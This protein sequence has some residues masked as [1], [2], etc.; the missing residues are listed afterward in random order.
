MIFKAVEYSLRDLQS[1][2]NDYKERADHWA[3]EFDDIW[4]ELEP[5]YDSND[6]GLTEPGEQAQLKS[7]LVFR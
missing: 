3:A 7:G 1:S 2:G 6:D 4:G 5:T